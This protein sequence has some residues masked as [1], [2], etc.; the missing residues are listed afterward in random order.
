[1]ATSNEI[2]SSSEKMHNN[3]AE[4]YEARMDGTMEE[5]NKIASSMIEELSLII[6]D[7]NAS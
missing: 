1:M 2:F 5:V 3:V 4:L 6:K 7:S